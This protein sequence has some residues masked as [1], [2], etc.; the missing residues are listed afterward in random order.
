[1][2]LNL[3]KA[4][5]ENETLLSL[6]EASGVS[7]IKLSEGLGYTYRMYCYK[8]NGTQTLNIGEINLLLILFGK[9]PHWSLCGDLPIEKAIDLLISEAPTSEEV[10]AVRLALGLTTK[11]IAEELGYKHDSWRT[12]E[13]AAKRGTLKMPEYNLL[14]LILGDHPSLKIQAKR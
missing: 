11:V 6:R 3:V 10:R 14:R 7:P 4:L 9:H 1:M 5:P 12:K 8:E 13:S 2:N